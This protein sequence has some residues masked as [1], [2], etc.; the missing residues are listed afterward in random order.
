M[1]A[2]GYR[3]ESSE[4]IPCNVHGTLNGL[5]DKVDN[6]VSPELGA[7]DEIVFRS[8]GGSGP[9]LSLS[10]QIEAVDYKAFA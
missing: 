1:R 2:R 6:L 4:R 10:D 3:E 7:V 5:F 9:A 8:H